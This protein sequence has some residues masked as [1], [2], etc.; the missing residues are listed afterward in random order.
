MRRNAIAIVL[1][2]SL[3]SACSM[4]ERA[5]SKSRDLYQNAIKQLVEAETSGSPLALQQAYQHAFETKQKIIDRY[6]STELAL[7]LASGELDFGVEGSKDLETTLLREAEAFAVAQDPVLLRYGLFDNARDSEDR[8][9]LTYYQ[10]G[11]W[12]LAQQQLSFMV[13]EW[14]YDIYPASDYGEVLEWIYALQHYKVPAHKYR[15][16]VGNYSPRNAVLSDPLLVQALADDDLERF[17][18]AY[19]AEHT[20]DE[21][22]LLYYL[23]S[24]GEMKLA[25]EFAS[26]LYYDHERLAAF[27]FLLFA[28]ERH[29]DAAEQVMST[30]LASLQ[31]QPITDLGELYSPLHF[32]PDSSVAKEIEQLRVLQLEEPFKQTSSNPPY[33]GEFSRTMYKSG[34]LADVIESYLLL[35]RTDKAELALAQA[36]QS[37]LESMNKADVALSL[38]RSYALLGRLQEVVAAIDGE[39]SQRFSHNDLVAINVHAGLQ[40]AIM[41]QANGRG[42]QADELLTQALSLPLNTRRRSDDLAAAI[43]LLVM[44]EGLGQITLSN[45]H[46]DLIRQ[47]FDEHIEYSHFKGLATF[48]SES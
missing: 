46:V 26:K 4:H 40:A 28:I 18:E 43:D 23:I 21:E 12:D 34:A 2:V 3:L 9:L 38:S 13:K 17:L 29:P 1:G 27:Q 36:E 6:P 32:Y 33:F 8:L 14:R 42:S 35:G 45:H 22:V 11:E 10:F 5:D 20:I 37:A 24:Q 31:T 16:F 44:A 41:A 48:R 19:V 39:H 7:L 47:C 25:A 15:D 30:I